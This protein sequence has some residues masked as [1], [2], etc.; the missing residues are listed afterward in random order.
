MNTQNPLSVPT[1]KHETSLLKDA[2]RDTGPCDSSMTGRVF[3]VS[4]GGVEL[5]NHGVQTT[6][7]LKHSLL[8][9]VQLDL[10]ELPNEQA[11]S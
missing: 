7:S 9:V 11:L 10:F 5:R 1:L 8:Q 6:R 3:I 2:L 4:E